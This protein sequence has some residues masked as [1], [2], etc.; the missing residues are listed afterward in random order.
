MN[1]WVYVVLS[2]VNKAIFLKGMQSFSNTLLF[3]AF[4]KFSRSNP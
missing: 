4:C 2:Y 1:E 3:L